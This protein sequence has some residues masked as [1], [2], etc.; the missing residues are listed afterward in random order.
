MGQVMAVILVVAALTCIV[1]RYIA[2]IVEGT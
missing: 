1:G 2:S